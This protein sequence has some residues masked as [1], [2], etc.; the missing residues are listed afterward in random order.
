MNAPAGGRRPPG[1]GRLA[2]TDL[3]LCGLVAVILGAAIVAALG[4]RD[5]GQDARAARLE[6]GL[7]C[8]VCAGLSI[9]DSPAQMAQ[10]MRTVVDQQ[11]AAG[12]S[13]DQVRAFF[14]DRY[15]A[16]I[17]LTPPSSGLGLGLWVAPGAILGFGLVL[18]IVFRGRRPI[19][20]PLG[21]TPPGASGDIGG[22]M[23]RS[24]WLRLGLTGLL[25]AAVGAP[26]A[27]AIGPRLPGQQISGEPAAPQASVSIAD[28]EA[29][30][31]ARPSDVPMLAALGD[32]YLDAG[33]TADAVGS[34]ERALQ[35]DPHN[36]PSLLGLGVILL[37]AGRPAAAG[38]LFDQVLLLSPD[39]PDAL[40][41]RALARD[42]TDGGLT[43]PARADLQ[44]FVSV[45]PDD[46][47]RT[48]AE[49]LLGAT[50]VS[51]SP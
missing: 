47:R 14:V 27:L 8:P 45:A 25:V 48:M 3:L 20:R 19:D 2:R 35:A 21:A 18:L 37:G 23:E 44:R 5:L 1:L 49:Q 41:Y 33:R 46:P 42:E 10:Q 30:A 31:R 7:R 28:L 36:V 26:L 16:W 50:A 4:P 43:A 40:F 11:L 15:G 38:P 9:A 22:R 39:L 12:A 6:A 51:P 29:A 34:F 32:A 24:A 13:D 17:L